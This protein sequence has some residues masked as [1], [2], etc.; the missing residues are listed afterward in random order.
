MSNI[1]VLMCV[2]YLVSMAPL[3]NPREMSN[4]SMCISEVTRL[5]NKS[6]EYSVCSFYRDVASQHNALSTRQQQLHEHR[7]LI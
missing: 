2:V 7:G 3:T 6:T 1:D 5:A 4:T